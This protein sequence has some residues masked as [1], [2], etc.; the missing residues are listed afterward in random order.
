[1]TNDKLMDA[2]RPIA[3]RSNVRFLLGSPA[4]ADVLKA[5]AD[6]A[7]IDLE[8]ENKAVT[9]AYHHLSQSYNQLRAER[10]V[11][12]AAYARLNTKC[13]TFAAELKSIREVPR[14]AQEPLVSYRHVNAVGDEQNIR[15]RQNQRGPL[16]V[17]AVDVRVEPPQ[18]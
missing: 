9:E 12:A 3:L 7:T 17:W 15:F 18:T 13:D 14:P 5:A 8:A 11:L 1:M 6:A 2:I 16:P 10:D 4:L